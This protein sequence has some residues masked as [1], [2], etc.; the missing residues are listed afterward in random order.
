MED[1]EVIKERNKL[2][3]LNIEK[4]KKIIDYELIEEMKS[5]IKVTIIKWS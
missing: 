5:K 1:I 2:E 3:Q 4:C